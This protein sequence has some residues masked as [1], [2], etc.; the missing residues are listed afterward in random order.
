[1]SL[2]S[3]SVS[4][5]I[6]TAMVFIGIIILGIFSFTRLAIDILPSLEPPAISVITTYPG[7]SSEDVELKVTKPIEDQIST[8]SNVTKVTSS[9]KDNLSIITATFSW[10]TN[11]DEAANNIR[12]V[13]D[14]VKRNLPADAEQ[15][16]LFRFSGSSIPVMMLGVSAKEDYPALKKIIT[17]QISDPLSRLP[18]VGAAFMMGG[19]ERKFLVEVDPYKLQGYGM[20]IPQLANAIAAENVT[21]PA[22]QIELG[23]TELSVRVPGEFTSVQDLKNMVVGVSGGAYIH[24]SDVAHVV[25]SLSKPQSLV[26]IDDNVGALVFVQKQSGANTVEVANE[27]MKALP[28]IKRSLPGD[29]T[30]NVVFDTSE[31]IRETINELAVEVLL[32]ALFVTLVVLAFLRQLRGSLIVIATIPISLVTAFAYLYFS[33]GTIN[34]ISLSSLAIAVGLVV[35]DAIVILDNISRHIE[36]GEKPGTASIVA[37]NEVGLAVMAST[38]TIVAVFLPL[39]FLTGIA[40]FFFKQLGGLVTV[41]VLVSLIAALSFTPMLSSKFLISERERSIKQIWVKKLYEASEKMFVNLESIYGKSL[42]WA[43]THK[44]ATIGV[45]ALVFISSIVLFSFVGTEFIPSFDTGSVQITVQMP[46]GTTVDSTVAVAMRA[47][48]ILKEEI[49]PQYREFIFYRAGQSSSGMSSVTGQK[50]GPNIAIISARLVPYSQR[51]GKTSTYFAKK[52]RPRLARIP[53]I[54]SYEVGSGYDIGSVLLGGSKPLQINVSGDDQQK[55]LRVAKQILSIVSSTPGAA[56]ASVSWGGETPEL[57]IVP[58]KD[59]MSSLG[60][61]SAIVGAT[62]RASI[63]GIK[64]SIFREV[65]DEYDIFI[66]PP[67]NEKNSVDYIANLPVKSMSGQIIPLSNFARIES[68]L[69]PIEIQHENKQRVIYVSSNVEGRALGDVVNEVKAKIASSVPIPPGIQIQ[70]GGQVREQQR[71]FQDLLV[72]LILSIILVYMVMASQFE[73]LLD[74]F[75]IMFSVPF[76]FTGV[77][78]ALWITKTPL[79][80]TAFIGLILLVGIVVKNAIVLIDYINI[81]RARNYSLKD[82]IVQGGKNR[83]RPVLMTA[84][85]MILGN[86]PMALST[87]VSAAFWKPLGITVVGG[88]LVS[89]LVTLI[90]VPVVYSLFETRLK[91]RFNQNHL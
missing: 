12:D 88:L 35:D 67:Y 57:R 16:M 58:D 43:L 32:G 10:G 42:Q 30:L 73:S 13:L 27:I 11:L 37:S 26:N 74:P 4:K 48:K 33:G 29:V 19:P 9:S 54:V 31:F 61:N 86:V 83:L 85:A 72:D 36:N 25:D 87:A 75:V 41:M 84:F 15:P 7:A 20:T 45:S 28:E 64:A 1:M 38:L 39:A 68:G 89:S 65:G 69:A 77:A 51:I 66:Q 34:M 46:V 17:D 18:G 8:V 47:E 76:A 14:R 63:Y 62:V 40:G 2:P 5:P 91:I 52:I 80:L 71:S 81:L 70:Y 24:L 21:V 53:G 44:L 22:G 78:W 59:K 6:T 3:T 60:L 23:R 56:D 82:A 55:S 90:L 49:P 79:G 50:E